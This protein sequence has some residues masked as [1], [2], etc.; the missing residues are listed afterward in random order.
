MN[1]KQY[2]LIGESI[3]NTYKDIA[4][5]LAEAKSPKE[6]AEAIRQV[7]PDRLFQTADE[8]AKEAFKRR[9]KRTRVQKIER[10][11]RELKG[12]Y[13]GGPD[14]RRAAREGRARDAESQRQFAALPRTN[15]KSWNKKP[16][17]KK[18]K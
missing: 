9:K 6:H 8:A 4:Y 13:I 1:N 17:L 11:K 10:V 3:W 2:E 12:G 5:I 14:A 7:T 18:P 16:F 15:I